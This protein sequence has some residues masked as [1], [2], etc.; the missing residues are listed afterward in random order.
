MSMGATG[1][2]YFVPYQQDINVALE[3]LNDD[4]FKQGQ[5]EQ[6]FNFNQ[7]EVERRLGRLLASVRIAP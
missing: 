1:W 4:V 6:S 2:S 3:E 7:N 5:Y